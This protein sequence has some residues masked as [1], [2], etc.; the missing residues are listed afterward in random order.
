MG[1]QVPQLLTVKETAEALGVPVGALRRVAEK[2]GYLVRMGRAIRLDPET[3]PELIERCRDQKLPPASTSAPT[4]AV[5]S[6]SATAAESSARARET[7]EKLKARS[8]VTSRTR[9]DRQA[10]VIP[11]R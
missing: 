2:H 11:I 9:T 8:R 6:T 3:L 10:R 1:K 5:Y 4:G 7:A